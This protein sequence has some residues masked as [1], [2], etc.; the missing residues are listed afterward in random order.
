[1]CGRTNA[2][3]EINFHDKFTLRGLEGKLDNQPKKKKK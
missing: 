1:M 2:K 3:C